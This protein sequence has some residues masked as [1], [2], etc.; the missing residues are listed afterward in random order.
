MLGWVKVSFESAAL[1]CVGGEEEE[2]EE[3]GK[4]RKTNRVWERERQVDRQTS[5]QADRETEGRK[6]MREKKGTVRKRPK[7]NE[8]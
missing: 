2:K 8:R 1:I 3:R 7:N 5:K 6:R 4:V